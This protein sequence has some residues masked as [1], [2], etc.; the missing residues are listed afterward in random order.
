M[1]KASD[2]AYR[3]IR[4]KILDGSLAP[5][6][7]LT[8]EDVADLCGVS[9]TPVRTAIQRLQTEMFLDKTDSQRTFVSKWSDD[10]IEDLF[11][12]RTM[13]ESHVADRAARAMTDDILD[14]LRVCC[15]EGRRGI[16]QPEPDVECFLRQ[17]AEFHRLILEAAGSELLATMMSRLML[18]PIVYQ[19]AQRYDRQRLVQSQ[20]DHDELI[21][22]FEA[23]DPAWASAIMAAHLRRAR[24]TYFALDR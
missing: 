3:T 1:S 19:T 13:L 17:N 18:V 15:E 23:R 20:D 16:D 8:E 6:I 10:S 24:H 4:T 14:R 5:G 7:Q 21:T 2:H 12:L 11:V 22:A 9:R